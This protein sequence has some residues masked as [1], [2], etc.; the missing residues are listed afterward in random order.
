MKL[1]RHHDLPAFTAH[2]TP[3]LM[4]RECENCF[5]LGT[6]AAPAIQEPGASTGLLP[7]LFSVESE[8]SI[9]GVGLQVQAFAFSIARIPLQAVEP[10]AQTLVELNWPPTGLVG[11]VEVSDA[12]SARLCELRGWTRRV[13]LSLR[14]FQLT[15]VMPP[16]PV[17]GRM[18][19]AT[20]DHLDVLTEW[21]DAYGRELQE[22]H[23]DP[24]AHAQR[25]IGREQLYV[26]MDGGELRSLAGITGPTPNG[27][28]INQVYT[29]PAFR[30]RG[31]ATNLVAALSRSMLDSGR[32][33]CFLNTDQANPTSNKIYQQIGYE[34]VSDLRHWRFD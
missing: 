15:S 4:Q 1:L 26:W 24:R 9:R 10:L 30:R 21:I 25:R 29:P 34:P 32:K 3:W 2:V 18:I 33:F 23:D 7:L 19:R 20:S 17:S 28:R 8:G 16:R 31:Y 12:L 27:I 5:Q 22:P 14:V 6:L 11:P 13:H